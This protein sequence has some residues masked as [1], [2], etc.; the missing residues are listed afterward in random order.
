V[1][2][3]KF[4]ESDLEAELAPMFKIRAKRRWG[5]YFLI[6]RVVH[7]LLTAPAE[8]RFG[9]PINAVARAVQEADSQGHGPLGHVVG[10]VLVKRTQPWRG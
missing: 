6:S 4:R 7:P 2:A 9:A 5:T 3:I 8:P 1:S 10:Y